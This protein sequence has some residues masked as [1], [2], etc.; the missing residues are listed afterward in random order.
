M[1]HIKEDKENKKEFADNYD[2][3]PT[4][5]IGWMLER[6]SMSKEDFNNIIDKKAKFRAFTVAKQTSLDAIERTKELLNKTLQEGETMKE[7][8]DRLKSDEIL[9]KI[10]FHE[11]NPFYL[12]TVFRTNT[13]SAYN[14]GRW[15]EIQKYKDDIALLEYVAI[16]DSRTTE[17][18]AALDGVRLPVDD[19]FWK[20]HYPPNHFNC[21]SQV[22]EIYIEEAKAL[23][24]KATDKDKISK[25][26]EV[27]IPKDFDT[28]IV[29][30]WWNLSDGMAKRTIDYGLKEEI[31]NKAKDLCKD[32]KF[33]DD[34]GG[35]CDEYFKVKNKLDG[36]KGDK[37]GNIKY[38]KNNLK[39]K[40]NDI[41]INNED[42]KFKEYSPDEKELIRNDIKSG[43]IPLYVSRQKQNSHIL[44][45]KEYLDWKSILT[46][47]PKELIEKYAGNGILIF[48]KDKWKQKE[49]FVSDRD[50][51]YYINSGKKIKTNKGIIVYS[52][53]GIHIYPINPKGRL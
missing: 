29:D 2:M 47:D 3:A 33:S 19:P 17:I 7:W 32:K 15:E 10:G 49:F 28:S 40:S 48:T 22:R 37:G 41:I 38:E 51:G 42:K 53:T 27:E 44:G 13:I 25:I 45:T 12:E 18:C 31:L 26:N 16:D 20:N 39:N 4:E 11:N 43:I 6:V 14:A 5:A 50:I 9:S 23:G 34:E 1:L 46:V 8:Y 21:R 35:L 24:Y 52:S 30:S 36:K